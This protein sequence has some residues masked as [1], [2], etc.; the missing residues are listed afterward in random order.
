M[1][2]IRLL[3]FAS[4]AMTHFGIFCEIIILDGFLEIFRLGGIPL[5]AELRLL[6]RFGVRFAWPLGHLNPWTLIFTAPEPSGDEG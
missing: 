1:E 4:L 5:G 3:C 2:D 6:F